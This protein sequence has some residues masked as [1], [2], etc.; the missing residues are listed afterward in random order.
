MSRLIEVASDQ[1]VTRQGPAPYDAFVHLDRELREAREQCAEEFEIAGPW[2]SSQLLETARSW[3]PTSPLR[4]RLLPDHT[5]GFLLARCALLKR[6]PARTVER[7]QV[8]LTRSDRGIK[9]AIDIVFALAALIILWPLLLTAAIAIKFDSVGPIL[10]RQRRS[11]LNGHHLVI[12]KFRSMTVL[13]DGPK[14]TQACCD[15]P[16]VTR[17]GRFLRRSSIDELPQLLN[18]LKGEMSLIGPRPHALAHDNEYSTQI[19]NYALRYHIKPGMTGWAQVNGLRGETADL[20]QMA[21]RVR[22]DLFYVKNWSLS[23]DILILLRTCFEIVRNR[24]Y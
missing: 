3:L 24:A 12:F 9:R 21:E 4:A 23:F 13:E 20:Q 8:P 6:W 14:V 11:G 15:D 2:S 18:V 22:L 19:A 16:R 1:M 10:F 5:I 17:V 7:Q